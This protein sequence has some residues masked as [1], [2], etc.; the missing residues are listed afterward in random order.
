MIAVRL[1]GKNDIRVEEIP[2]P[3]IAEDE[4]LLKVKAASICGTDVRMYQN[5]YTGITPD[6]PRILGHEFSGVIEQVGVNVSGYHRGQRVTVAPNMGC[7]I[8]RQCVSGN[9][10]LC[11]TYRAFGVN[12]DGGFAEYVRIP[13][14]A[15][16]QGNVAELAEQVSF[17]EA[18][19]NE[20]LSCVYNGT[21]HCLIRPGDSVVVIGAGPIGTMHG[22]L[23]K[24]AGAGKVFYSDLSADRLQ[25]VIKLNPFFKALSGDLKEAVMCETD[26]EGADVVITAC[27][28]PAAQAQAPE[29]CAIGGRVNFFGGIPADRQ[30]VPINTNLVHY[31]QLILTGTTRASVT[32]FRK[33][34]SFIRSGILDVKPLITGRFPLTDF[35]SGL[36]RAIRAEGMK[37][38]L[39]MD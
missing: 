6:S 27:P 30:P 5:G 13:A 7:G 11:P 1:Y 9:T 15:I 21:E 36:D 39:L 8:C 22:L 29:L 34:L 35:M 31:K 4:I 14:E 32:Q 17:E 38:V 3:T 10:H 28:S 33:T 24:M 16:R 12:I 2:K 19:L 37:N 25:A 20:P 26:G 18:A 23:A